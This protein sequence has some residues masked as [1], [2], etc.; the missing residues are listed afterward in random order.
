MNQAEQTQ[1]E[2]TQPQEVPISEAAWDVVEAGQRVLLDRI[3]LLALESRRAA[4]WAERQVVLCLLA[5]LLLA[6]AWIAING[7]AVLVLRRYIS[8]VGAG[9]AAAIANALLGGALL[10]WAWRRDAREL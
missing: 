1:P 4:V 10:A 2:E 8:L 3:E 9:G 6:T 5:V 7:A